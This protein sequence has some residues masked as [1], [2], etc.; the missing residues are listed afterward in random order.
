M[1]VQTEV[2]VQGE[3]VLVNGFLVDCDIPTEERLTLEV[4][5]TR[6]HGYSHVDWI[7]ELQDLLRSIDDGYRVEVFGEVRQPSRRT[8]KARYVKNP[9]GRMRKVALFHPYPSTLINRFKEVR[10]EVYS[11]LNTY[12]II[13]Q[14]ERVGRVVK[15]IYFLPAPSAAEFMHEIDSLNMRLSKIWEEVADFE[16]GEGFAKIIEHVKKAD[17]SFENF[18]AKPSQIRVSP[19]PL[20]LSRRFYEEFLEEEK[21][22]IVR[23][24]ER[25][26]AEVEEARRRSLAEIEE[27]R[28]MGLKALERELEERRREML[29]AIE[30]DLKQR[31]AAILDELEKIVA[32]RNKKKARALRSR[33][34]AISRLVE[35][36]GFFEEPVKAVENVLEAVETKGDIEEAVVEL[37]R[38][39]GVEP[40]GS[41]ERNLEAAKRAASGSLW[42]LAI[43]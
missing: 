6:M 17:P 11:V 40:L 37:V 34:N 26:M 31:F 16:R 25:S 4:D 10:R 20:S 28:L 41:V 22:K 29:S 7:S 27:K 9:D 30:R 13:L 35:G 19:V 12:C 38:S 24:M 5:L 42:L 8:V 2:Q 18:S 15:K 21:A 1:Q 32:S 23:E 14:Q 39:L 33:V 3:K 36:L 43:E